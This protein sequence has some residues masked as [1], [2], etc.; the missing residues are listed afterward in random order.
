M[1]V[2][3]DVLRSFAAQVDAVS[4][5]ISGL[6]VG[7]TATT[8]ADGLPGSETQWAARLVGEHLGLVATDIA[9]DIGAMGRAVRGAGDR[10]EVDDAALATSFKGLF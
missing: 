10:Y 6:D 7:K 2:D 4:A 9:N 1:L 8:S 3:P 5:E